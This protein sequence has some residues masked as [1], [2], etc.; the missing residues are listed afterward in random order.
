MVTNI[1]RGASASD[2]EHVGFAIG[3]LMTRVLLLMM[4]LVTWY[5]IR[6]KNEFFRYMTLGLAGSTVCFLVS[7]FMDFNVGRGLMAAGL[8]VEF[9]CRLLMQNLPLEKVR[10]G[11]LGAGAV[12]RFALLK[13]LWLACALVFMCV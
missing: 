13:T 9:L 10:W 12:V 5:Y 11:L 3:F 8:M 2:D 1:V 7:I 4:M 6:E